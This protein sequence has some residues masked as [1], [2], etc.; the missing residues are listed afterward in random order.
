MVTALAICVRGWGGDLRVFVA[1]PSG[2]AQDPPTPS[3]R[4]TC[5]FHTTKKTFVINCSF[6][7]FYFFLG[8]VVK[9]NPHNLKDVKF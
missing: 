7:P 1:E 9:N 5:C 8:G 4:R 6:S 2:E 3:P